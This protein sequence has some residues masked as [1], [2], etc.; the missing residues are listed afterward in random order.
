MTLG[1]QYHERFAD[2]RREVSSHLP[3]C[4]G[5]AQTWSRSLRSP[6][7]PSLVL[8]ATPLLPPPC[9]CL[10]PGREHAGTH[11]QG[12]AQLS[13]SQQLGPQGA[14]SS[15]GLQAEAGETH[16]AS[17]PLGEGGGPPLQCV[18]P[19]ASPSS[20]TG[21]LLQAASPAWCLSSPWDP[22]ARR[23][24]VLAWGQVHPP[25]AQGPGDPGSGS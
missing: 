22:R 6:A 5:Q 2:E 19:C 23:L 8:L 20:V 15:A 25:S 10:H 14:V 4:P 18:L 11:P 13:P 12:G 21:P 7:A 3:A 24:G 1:G 16:T 9:I 17:N